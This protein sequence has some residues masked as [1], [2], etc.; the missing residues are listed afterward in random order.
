MPFADDEN[1]VLDIYNIVLYQHEGLPE[2]VEFEDDG[3][4]VLIQALL[5]RRPEDRPTFADLQYDSFFREI[6]WRKLW[7]R[8]PR[9]PVDHWRWK[10]DFRHGL[11]CNDYWPTVKTQD[12]LTFFFTFEQVLRRTWSASWWASAMPL[13]DA[14]QSSQTFT[15]RI[16]RHPVV[17]ENS[18]YSHFASGKWSITIRCQ[19]GTG[20]DRQLPVV[21]DLLTDSDLQKFL[22]SRL[23]VLKTS[24]QMQNFFGSARPPKLVSTG[25]K[26]RKIW[27]MYWPIDANQTFRHFRLY[28]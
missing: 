10:K 28:L 5:S 6:D 27:K 17:L 12:L 9:A 26:H 2:Y 4:V 1:I 19:S 20:K 15:P 13:G 3:L 22:T 25:G 14:K 7:C 16:S 11:T 23:L 8:Q 18:Q 24:F 21:L